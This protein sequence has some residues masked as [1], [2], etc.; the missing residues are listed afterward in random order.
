MEKAASRERR[1]ENSRL[2]RALRELSAG[3]GPAAPR[4]VYV[5]F[6]PAL[7]LQHLEPW[8][9]TADLR[10]MELVTGGWSTFTP[11]YEAQLARLGITDV[12]TDLAKRHDMFLVAK[13]KHARHYITFVEEHRG[14][15]YG[16]KPMP[17]FGAVH[18]AARARVYRVQDLGPAPP[19]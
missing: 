14:R 9:D 11:A 15:R 2:V 5:L 4:P 12:Y 7:E 1:T 17:G 16:L 18:R 6:G 10:G 3:G 13:A 8:R 19:R